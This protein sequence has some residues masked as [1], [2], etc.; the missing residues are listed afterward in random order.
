M[1]LYE[2][3]LITMGN[4]VG[5]GFADYYMAFAGWSHGPLPA[6]NS[7][8]VQGALGALE[9]VT[10]ITNGLSSVIETASV[11]GIATRRRRGQRAQRC[12]D[13]VG[14]AVSDA[15]DAVGYALSDLF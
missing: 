6:G 10:N 12:A 14:G 15:A 5:W 2:A 4:N 1:A 3:D 11:G 13:A 8:G 9:G 7:T